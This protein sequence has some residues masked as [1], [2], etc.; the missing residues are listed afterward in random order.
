MAKILA[1]S[2]ALLKDDVSLLSITSEHAAA[3]PKHAKD[4]DFVAHLVMPVT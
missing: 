1:W 3:A 4:A 2:G